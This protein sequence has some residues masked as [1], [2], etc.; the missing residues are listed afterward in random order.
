VEALGPETVP[1]KHPAL[2]LQTT[3]PNG[4]LGHRPAVEGGLHLHPF[5]SHR[6]QK[7]QPDVLP[8][9]P[10]G[11]PA[12]AP[13]LEQALEEALALALALALEG[14]LAL[15]QVQVLQRCQTVQQ[16]ALPGRL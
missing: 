5:H 4:P 9:R 1:E 11:A 15:V 12:L 13:A 7:A 2:H 16:D 14:V 6:H 8:G 10:P 3:Q